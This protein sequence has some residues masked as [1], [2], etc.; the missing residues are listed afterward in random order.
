MW[1]RNNWCDLPNGLVPSLYLP[2]V[3]AHLAEGAARIA[4]IQKICRENAERKKKERSQREIL[5]WKLVGDACGMERR[6]LWLW[7]R[8]SPTY[9]MCVRATDTA[10]RDGWWKYAHLLVCKAIS[11]RCLLAEIEY[12]RCHMRWV[13]AP[14]HM[15]AGELCK[16]DFVS[17]RTRNIFRFQ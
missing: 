10:E 6:V 9:R 11:G 1:K 13:C 8:R 4:L 5:A 15:N 17:E 3:V 2:L 14:N 7:L 16:S 12:D